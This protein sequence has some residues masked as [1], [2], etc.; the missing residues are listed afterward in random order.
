MKQTHSKGEQGYF[1]IEAIVISVLLMGIASG[2]AL[3][4]KA[5]ELRNISSSRWGALYL[6]QAEM[7]Y[8]ESQT[9]TSQQAP[10]GEYDWLGDSKALSQNQCQYKVH[11]NGEP[12]VDNGSQVVVTVE[13]EC[14]GREQSVTLERQ[15]YVHKK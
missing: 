13:Y 7:A 11:A 4:Q 15:I 9:Y 5:V 1:F 14:A 10:T 3:F 2:I 8:L 12:L 6:A